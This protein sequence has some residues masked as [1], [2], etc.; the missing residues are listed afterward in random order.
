MNVSRVRNY[1][2]ILLLVITGCQ[3]MPEM[4]T[5]KKILHNEG[6]KEE[7]YITDKEPHLK[8]DRYY[9]WYKSRVL[10]KTLDN[11]SG[12]LADGP[13]VKY[14]YSSQMAEK[15][16]FDNGLKE[17]KWST[18]YENGQL[19]S[20]TYW[21]KGEEL[22][23]N[24][25]G[26]LLLKGRYRNG[27]KHGRWIHI[28]DGDTLVYKRGDRILKD[29]TT[30]DTVSKQF[31]L[32]RWLLSKEKDSIK[33]DSAQHSDKGFFGRLF[34]SDSTERAQRKIERD[35]E[36]ALKKRMKNSTGGKEK[37]KTSFLQKLFGKEEKKAMTTNKNTKK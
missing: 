29:T 20:V 11:Y 37:E 6:F 25:D 23:Y 4:I 35:R 32:S 27:K 30:N 8:N 28:E 2:V 24:S 14:Y 1:V 31:F 34:N 21:R 33:V 12:E 15:G 5:N 19:A 9:Y 16:I 36:K 26:D 22:H 3:S 10:H 13:Y 18:W 17:G 7:V